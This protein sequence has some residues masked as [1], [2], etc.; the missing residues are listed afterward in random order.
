M[1]DNIPVTPGTWGRDPDTGEKLI[2]LYCHGGCEDVI[3]W[4]AADKEGKP[5]CNECRGRH[6]AEAMEPNRAGECEHGNLR[7]KCETCDLRSQLAEARQEVV[8]LRGQIE[9]M[10]SGHQMDAP[11]GP[12]CVCGAPSAH[13]S[14]WCGREHQAEAL[15]ALLAE[16]RPVLER[17]VREK[18]M[19]VEDRKTMEALLARWPR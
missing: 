13:E 4:P 16:V 11:G 15:R 6:A 19:A 2:A 7:R 9:L 10:E 3:W 5:I 12:R 14:G 18:F 8:R 17:C 1:S